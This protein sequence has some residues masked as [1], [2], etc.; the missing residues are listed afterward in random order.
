[1]PEDAPRPAHAGDEG[2]SA[3]LAAPGMR[4]PAPRPADRRPLYAN[5]AWPGEWQPIGYVTSDA[6]LTVT[7]G[8]MTY[9]GMTNTSGTLTFNITSS[10]SAAAR[11]F[12]LNAPRS[13]APA[14]PRAQFLGR[15]CGRD[16]CPCSV[17]GPPC[18]EFEGAP[19]EPSGACFRCGWNQAGHDEPD[20]VAQ[21]RET[22]RRQR[23]IRDRTL[24]DEQVAAARREHEARQARREE[25]RARARATL[26]RWLTD[27]QRAQYEDDETF[28]VVGS[29]GGRYRI[30][31]GS[32]GNVDWIDP[33]AGEP[34]AR[35]C[36]HPDLYA[37][38][39][40][41]DLPDPDIALAQMLHLATDE[42]GWL[43]IAN[44]H[45]AA[46]GRAFQEYAA[47]LSR[48]TPPAADPEELPA[49]EAPAAVGTA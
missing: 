2:S 32:N 43:A 47:A 33:A 4:A 30:R 46:P 44:I 13:P 7:G 1:M 11:R 26:L 24:R 41:D 21:R 45:W 49:P 31:R 22:D 12:F 10:V 28:Y 34:A 37:G 40:I 18:E 35:L 39:A 6:A 25:A 14:P 27:E 19:D 29:A 5:T 38:G 36:A 42:A 3:A 23:V 15:F 8:P 48:P 17:A 16:G 20:P 9:G